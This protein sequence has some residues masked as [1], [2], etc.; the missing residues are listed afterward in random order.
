[1]TATKNVVIYGAGGHAKVVHDVVTAAGGKVLG[2]VDDG[3][4]AGDLVLGLPV[5]GGAGYLEGRAGEFS[6]A[7]GIGGNEVRARCYDTAKRLGFA[8]PAWVHPSATVSPSVTLDEG[9]VV[10]PH[11]VVNAQA[12]LGKGVIV[13]TSVVVEHDCQVGDFVHLAPRCVLAG[14]SKVQRL[15]HFGLGASI[16]QSVTVGEGALVG[17]GAVVVRDVAAH[18]VAFGVPARARRQV[19]PKK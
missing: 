14:A 2:Y 8:M 15:A 18:T 16:I 5:F 13:N 3:R 4:K 11:A 19:G 7:L 9:V 12:A 1:M 10:M 6:I 17:A